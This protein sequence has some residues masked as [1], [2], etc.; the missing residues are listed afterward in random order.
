MNMNRSGKRVV[1]T[2]VA[3]TFL[4]LG[5]ADVDAY[6]PALTPKV[7]STFFR[8]DAVFLAK[9]LSETRVVSDD[10]FIEGWR[11]RVRVKRSF[12][13]ATSGTVEVYTENTSA[14][15]PLNVGRDY[16]LFA[17]MAKGRLLIASDCGPASDE[18]RT[19]ANV[20]EIESLSRRTSATV[21]GEVRTTAS[22][23]GVAGI[24]IVISG[25]GQTHRTTSGV[26]GGF[27]VV[28]PPGQYQVA[29]DPAV[30]VP[31]DLNRID[32]SNLNLRPGECAQLLYISK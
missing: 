24:P 3:A 30:A 28:L 27:R 26:H 32:E 20:R 8:S 2:T 17:D 10:D 19:A 29:V 15:R 9:V 14:R 1:A 16:L 13:G 23:S 25:M 21:E 31:Y 11:Y 6:C 22:G 18:S 7:C 4:L 5:H 12:R